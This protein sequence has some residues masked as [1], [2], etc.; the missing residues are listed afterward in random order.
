ME[1]VGEISEVLVERRVSASMDPP[2]VWI[3]ESAI[4]GAYAE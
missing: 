1:I 2:K 3:I 4:V